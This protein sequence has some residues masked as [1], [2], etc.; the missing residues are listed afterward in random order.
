ML[1]NH[2]GG[3]LRMKRFES[4]KRRAKGLDALIPFVTLLRLLLVAMADAMD[5]DG[6]SSLADKITIV[7]TWSQWHSSRSLHLT[8]PDSHTAPRLRIGLL[9]G[10]IFPQGGGPHAGQRPSM[11]ADEGVSIS[12]KSLL[13]PMT[14]K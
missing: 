10:H 1:P 4:D 9:G 5:V 6:S 3:A 13:R 14:R 7:S 2:V 12:A 11:D 8:R